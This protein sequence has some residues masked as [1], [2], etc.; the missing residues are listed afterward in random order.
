M[1]YDAPLRVRLASV[2]RRASSVLARAAG[3]LQREAELATALSPVRILTTRL[4]KALEN[5]QV[6]PNSYAHNAVMGTLRN[7]DWMLFYPDELEADED[8]SA[9]ATAYWT[10]LAREL[11]AHGLELIVLLVPDK[12]T[13]YHE[14]LRTPLAPATRPGQRMDRLEHALRAEGVAV[15]NLRSAFAAAVPALFARG[16]Y[17]Y[18]RDDTHWNPRGV[19]L[20]AAE[21]ARA[22]RAEAGRPLRP[23]P[24]C[25]SSTA[26]GRR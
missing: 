15:V 13:V 20:A 23:L 17:L 2:G 26:G 8:D 6:L 24:P 11:R 14:L 21:I 1:G 18:W 22:A 9:P 12:H 25:G 10:S 19:H 4:H 3:R 7:G 5:E 16:E